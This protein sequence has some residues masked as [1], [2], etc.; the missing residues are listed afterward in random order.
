MS[1]ETIVAK[2]FVEKLRIWMIGIGIVLLAAFGMEVGNTD[3]DLNS[4]IEGNSI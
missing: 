3:I 2:N 4:M 1:K